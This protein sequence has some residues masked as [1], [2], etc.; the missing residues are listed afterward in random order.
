M[1][2]SRSSAT[3]LG[4]PSDQAVLKSKFPQ[5]MMHQLGAAGQGMFPMM[6]PN[7]WN[8]PMNQ[9]SQFFGNQ[10]VPPVGFNHMM[11]LP[12]GG[13]PLMLLNLTVRGVVLV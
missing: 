1:A 3:P 8:L 10:Q 12:Y 5:A 13:S 4:A 7:M 2:A 11:M 6:Q 9:W